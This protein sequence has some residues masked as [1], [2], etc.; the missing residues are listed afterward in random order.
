MQYSTYL[1]IETTGLSPVTCRLTV[2]GIY[3]ENGTDSKVV[4]L[5]GDEICRSGLIAVLEGTEMLYTYNGARFDLPF[6]RA[7]LDID[8]TEYYRHRDLLYACRKRNLYGGLKGVERQLGIHRE[9]Q[10]IDGRAAVQLWHNYS[11]Y[12]DRRSLE[13]LLKYNK[14]DVMNLRVLRERLNL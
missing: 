9:L 5:V 11:R 7:K 12:G 2:I 4:Q 10:D 6:I 8:L 13:M 14:E 3:R 1:D